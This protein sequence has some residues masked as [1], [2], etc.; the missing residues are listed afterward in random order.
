MLELD[1][2]PYRLDLPESLAWIEADYP[3]IVEFKENR[4]SKEKPRFQ[5]ERL[6]IDLANLPERRKM[7]VSVNARAKKM[8]VLTEGVVPYLSLEEVASLADDLRTSIA[9]VTGS[10]NTFRLRPLNIGTR[11]HEPRHAKRSLQIRTRR[12]VR[13][14]RSARLA[15]PE[16][17]I[18]PT[19]VTASIAQSSCLHF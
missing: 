14:L 3:H 18:C 7:F 13:F 12:L 17:R 1:T 8:L 6:K 10:S 19:K 9:P 11:S 4:L 15:S 2:R 5:L 16:I